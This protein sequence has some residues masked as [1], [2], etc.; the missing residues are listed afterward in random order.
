MPAP[1]T[2]VYSQLSL[3][4]LKITETEERYQSVTWISLKSGERE[5]NERTQANVK[6]MSYNERLTWFYTF[7]PD[8]M[9][10]FVFL[11]AYFSLRMI[12]KKLPFTELSDQET[13][14]ENYLENY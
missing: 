14:K 1:P 11:W 7:N 5:R 9:G 3:E 10:L 4:Y 2:A 6:T 12:K 13:Q 8:K